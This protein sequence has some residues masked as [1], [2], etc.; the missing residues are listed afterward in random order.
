M[1]I[2][3]KRT[4]WVICVLVVSATNV[5]CQ[6]SEFTKFTGPYL[7]QQPPE[8]TPQIFAPGIISFGYHEHRITISPNGDEIYY[9]AASADDSDA[10]IMFT[11]IINGVWTIPAVA[12]FSNKGM[13]LH[14]AFSP[15][16]KRLY[17]ASTRISESDGKLT[18]DADIWFVER[19]GDNWSE[20]IHLPNSVNTVNSESS[21]SLMTD[22]TLYFERIISNDKRELDIYFSRFEN[23]TFQD[24]IKLSSPVNSNYTD[25]GPFI[26]PDGSYLLFYSNRPG[27]FGKSDIYISFIN[28][29]GIWKE[30]INLGGEINSAFI[31]WSPIITPDG[32]YLIFSS[33]R[34]TE[35]IVP[36]DYTYLNSMKTYFGNPVPGLG[37]LYWVDA[38]IIHELRK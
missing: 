15:D 16:G 1:S 18:E 12:S 17:F 34:N 7:D 26:S 25:L 38:S 20:P 9:S 6:Q 33:Y 3:I 24:A 37:T 27:A 19:R 31:D 21:P 23:N 35:P 13:N 32:K 22:G 11:K 14:P 28:D 10:Q 30:P 2:S 5:F 36:V 29:E 4:Y 8:A